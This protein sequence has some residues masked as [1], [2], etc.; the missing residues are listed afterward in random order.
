VYARF[1]HAAYNKGTA[2]RELMRHHG[3]AAD[4]VFAAGDHLNDLPMLSRDCAR[5]L[6]V[7]QNAV[8][9]VKEAV[10]R[11]QGFVSRLAHGDGVAEGLEHSLREAMSQQLTSS[12]G[13][14][15]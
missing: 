13:Q 5:W 1:C 15:K 6:A 3:L 7:P 8:E 11:Q 14:P 2:L 12:P 4:E 10:R 9:P